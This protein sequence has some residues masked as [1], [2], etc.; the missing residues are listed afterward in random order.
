MPNVPRG[1]PKAPCEV[2]GQPTASRFGVCKRTLKC[3][4]EAARRQHA[5]HPEKNVERVRRWRARPEN[6]ERV[7]ESNRNYRLAHPE[8]EKERHRRYDEDQEQRREDKRR[9]AAE[10]RERVPEDERQRR[11]AD[12]EQGQEYRRRYDTDAAELE[13]QRDSRR[14][15]RAKHP[16]RDRETNRRYFQREDRPCA[17]QGDECSSEFAIRGSVYCRTHKTADDSARDKRRRE[18]V[19]RR[20]AKTQGGICTWCALPLPD[21]LKGVHLDHVIPKAVLVIEEDWNFEALHEKCNLAKLD[22]LTDRAVA[23]AAE[24]GIDLRSHP[25]R[26]RGARRRHAA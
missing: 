11:A 12:W 4:N 25:A 5:E 8:R 18:R 23:L 1:T 3:A 20:H 13:R 16:E 15:F 6:Y 21:D 14:R 10:N 26:R 7:L 9:L 24:H 17:H 19:L 2:C 22:K